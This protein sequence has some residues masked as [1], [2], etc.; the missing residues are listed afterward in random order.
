MEQKTYTRAH[1]VLHWLIAFTFLF[2]LLTVFLRTGWLNKDHTADIILSHAAKMNL[3]I[4]REQAVQIGREIRRPMWNWHVYAG[5]FMVVL[6]VIRLVVMKMQDP[7]FA[8]PFIKNLSIK[9]RS[10]GAVYLAFYL[11][12]GIT[13]L[14]GTFVELGG[15]W[16]AARQVMKTIHVQALYFALAFIIVHFVGL[17]FAELTNERGVVSK[18]IH[19]K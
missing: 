15:Q 19:G 13:L 17:V 16:K 1:R 14:S 10:K 2:I 5:Y 6:Y 9:E 11:I 4:S 3:S 12:L 8:N 7:V 18:M